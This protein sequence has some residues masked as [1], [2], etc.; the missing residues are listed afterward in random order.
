MTVRNVPA[1][2]SNKRAKKSRAIP[3]CSPS[4]RSRP[5][6]K[7]ATPAAPSMLFKP[8][9]ASPLPLPT[10]ALNRSY[11]YSEHSMR[12]RQEIYADAW[13]ALEASAVH[14]PPARPSVDPTHSPSSLA[15]RIARARLGR[16]HSRLSPKSPTSAEASDSESSPSSS[17]RELPV[18][19]KREL[20]A[21]I[22]HGPPPREYLRACVDQAVVPS[23]CL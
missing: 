16:K 12:T 8:Y 7:G 22:G 17:E 14:D 9:H 23:W 20:P 6:A 21:Y 13:N 5:D 19:G 4:A 1:E 15:S 3:G 2:R 18:G 11:T 10:S